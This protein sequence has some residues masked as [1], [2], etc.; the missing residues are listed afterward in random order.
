MK[1]KKQL[2]IYLQG[3]LSKEKYN[4]F[5]EQYPTDSSTAAYILSLAYNDGNIADRNIL[6]LGTG[7]GVFACGAAVLG[8]KS[9][10][11][12]DVD[13]DQ[14]AVARENCGSSNVQFIV[15][16]ARSVTGHFDTV[17]MNAPFGS[18][19]SHADMPFL[20]KAVDVGDF[21][22]S[23]H[24]AKSKDFV[25]NFYAENGVIFREE[26]VNIVVG[27]LYEHHTRDRANIPGVFFSVKT[28]TK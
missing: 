6:D 4:N 12:I 15:Q 26:Q 28:K 3:L 11:G 13:G 20:E 18:V 10:V 2:E 23:I 22:Y 14:I 19:N 7:N 17:I 5:L 21:V 8:C 24:N 1:G 16:N 27:R 25:R 9:V